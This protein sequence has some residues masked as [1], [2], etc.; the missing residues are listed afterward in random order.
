MCNAHVTSPRSLRAR[1][2]FPVAGP[3]LRD[4]AVTISQGRIIAVGSPPNNVPIEDLGQVAIVPGLVNAH[5]HLEFSDLSSPIGLPGIGL[6]EWLGSVIRHRAS[7]PAQ[8]RSSVE[9]GLRESLGYG[10]TTIGEIAQPGGTSD[11][12]LA[13]SCEGTIFLELIAPRVERIEAVLESAGKHLLKAKRAVAEGDLAD[14][15]YVVPASG[16]KASNTTRMWRPGLSPHAPYTAHPELLNRA[17]ELSIEHAIPLAMHLA[18]SP[19]EIELLRDGCGPFR[20][21][22]ESRSVWDPTARSRGA[23]PLDELH[24][25]ARAHRAL[26]IHGNFLDDEEIAFLGRQR[27]QMAVVYCPRTHARFGH[28]R[29]PL[30]KLLAAGAIVALGTDSRASAPDLSLLAEMRHV[31]RA[32]P[33]MSRATILQMGTR[34][35]AQALGL[36]A[37]V[38][39]LEPGRWAN[40]AVVALP[41]DAATDPHALLLDAAGAVI[42]TWFRGKCVSL[43]GGR[44]P[45]R[46]Q[47]SGRDRAPGE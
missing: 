40:L 35:G 28:A 14:H 7:M 4:S 36:D 12:Y 41:E 25:L 33:A 5:T 38:G 17:V 46:R 13:S 42:S 23:R 18:E 45:V 37:Q 26:V 21:L 8:S 2:V 9:M 31:A 15:E 39:S 47:L 44:R 34:G 24:V 27:R 19:E 43:G 1:W 29:Y 16:F 32:F 22:L 3:P 30:E 10:V 6:V 20:E 11:P